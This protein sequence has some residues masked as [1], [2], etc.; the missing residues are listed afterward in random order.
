MFH[1]E[2]RG[3]YQCIHILIFCQRRACRGTALRTSACISDV[4]GSLVVQSKASDE[5]VRETDR[6]WGLRPHSS[7]AAG[8]T[9]AIS[10]GCEM[11]PRARYV[12]AS[13]LRKSNLSRYPSTFH[14]PHMWPGLVQSSGLV[15]LV[16]AR[17]K[18]PPWYVPSN[19]AVSA[20]LLAWEASYWGPLRL[21]KAKIPCR[22]VNGGIESVWVGHPLILLSSL[23][24]FPRVGLG[25]GACLRVGREGWA[26][27]VAVR[28]QRKKVF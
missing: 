8:A 28:L 15:T 23:A 3:S 4:A 22:T 1:R 20:W 2:D 21:A 5:G 24:V 10:T 14:S 27:T 16:S 7:S 9:K 12:M 11:H 19:T 26:R 17:A 6:I 25:T 18:Y 13:I